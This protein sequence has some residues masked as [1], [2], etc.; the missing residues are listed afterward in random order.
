MPGMYT[1]PG[2]VSLKPPE[3]PPY[4]HKY[5]IYSFGLMMAQMLASTRGGTGSGDA[6]E[7]LWQ[8][9]M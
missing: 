1:Y 5:D 3:S 9:V 2:Y 7:L 6:A 4:T 8:Q